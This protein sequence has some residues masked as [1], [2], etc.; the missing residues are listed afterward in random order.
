MKLLYVINHALNYIDGINQ[1]FIVKNCPEVPN[2]PGTKITVIKDD[3]ALLG[4]N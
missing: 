2:I 1:I 3:N 4:V